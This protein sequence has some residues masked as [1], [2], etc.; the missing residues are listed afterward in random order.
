MSQGITI[1]DLG[2]GGAEELKKMG[3]LLQG[4]VFEVH[5]PGKN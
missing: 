1:Y 3:A 2:R 4:N 5:G